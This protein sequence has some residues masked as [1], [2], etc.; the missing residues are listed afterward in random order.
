M[1]HSLIKKHLCNLLYGQLYSKYKGWKMKTA[2]ILI[3]GYPFITIPAI[4]VSLKI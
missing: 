1:N 2:G 3:K 4:A